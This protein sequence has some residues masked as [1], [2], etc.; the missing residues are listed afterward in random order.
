[1]RQHTSSESFLCILGQQ[2]ISRHRSP[3]SGKAR[4]WPTLVNKP[5]QAACLGTDLQAVAPSCLWGFSNGAGEGCAGCVRED[6]VPTPTYSKHILPRKWHYGPCS[7]KQLQKESLAHHLLLYFLFFPS[8][9]IGHDCPRAVG[10]WWCG[11]PVGRVHVTPHWGHRETS[12]TSQN[13][14]TSGG[15]PEGRVGSEHRWD[16]YPIPVQTPS[17]WLW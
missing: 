9:W 6:I 4:M 2:D 15:A 3:R 11:Y 16:S 5:H 10:T 1:M 17:G 12:V 14:C 7:S 8:P 13:F